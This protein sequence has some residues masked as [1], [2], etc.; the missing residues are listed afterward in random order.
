[1]GTLYDWLVLYAVVTILAG[2]MNLFDWT[3]VR[4]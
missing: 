1:M 3:N 2:M 4:K